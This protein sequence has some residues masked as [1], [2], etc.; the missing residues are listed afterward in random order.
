MAR[1][2]RINDVT[3]IPCVLDDSVEKIKTTKDA[4]A[5]LKLAGAYADVEKCEASKK[6]RAGKGKIRNR[7]KVMRRGPLVV[8]NRNDGIYEAFRN[9]PGVDLCPVS[10]LGLL[11]LA[12]GGHVGRFL[13][14][15]KSAFNA[16]DAQYGTFTKKASARK[17]QLPQPIM[18][19]ADVVRII[20]SDEVQAVVAPAKSGSSKGFINKNPLNNLNALLKLNPY[21]KTMKRNAILFEQARVAAKSK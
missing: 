4:V 1:G 15:S 17:Y 18:G 19:N 9:I 5:A 3:E 14:F 6:I 12:P 20:N 8:Y 11:Q 2:H 13:I 16:L 7:R 21:A 10:S